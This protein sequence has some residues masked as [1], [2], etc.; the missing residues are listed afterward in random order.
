MSN[1]EPAIGNGGIWIK[2]GKNGKKYLS[3]SMTFPVNANVPIVVHGVA[4]KNEKKE[5]NQ[6][7]YRIIVNGFKYPEP[8]KEY[9]EPKPEPEKERENDGD[10]PF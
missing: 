7:D 8:R 3:W 9:Q 2:D 1:Y 6:P 5:G 10:I 4:F